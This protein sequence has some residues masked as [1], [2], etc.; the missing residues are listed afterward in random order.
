MTVDG[1]T[2]DFGWSLA[3]RFCSLPPGLTLQIPIS[4]Y[5]WGIPLATT[6]LPEMLRL[7]ARKK[8]SQRNNKHQMSKSTE[9]VLSG[10]SSS[11][12]LKHYFWVTKVFPPSTEPVAEGGNWERMGFCGDII[13]NNFIG[14]I[15]KCPIYL[16]LIFSNY[17]VETMGYCIDAKFVL[18]PPPS[19]LRR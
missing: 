6:R 4:L 7:W 12:L 5:G 1:Y 16:W 13:G 11:K 9:H 17:N 2:I 18:I 10:K 15:Y 8:H 19:P 3:S 14:I